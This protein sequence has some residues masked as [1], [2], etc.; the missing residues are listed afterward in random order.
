MGAKPPPWTS[1]IYG[2]QTPTGAKLPC[3]KK[4]ELDKFLTTPLVTTPD[5]A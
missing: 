4:C 5:N 1:E 3:G 2:F